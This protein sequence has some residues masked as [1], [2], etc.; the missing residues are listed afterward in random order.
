MHLIQPL[1]ILFAGKH[2]SQSNY[3]FLLL[4]FV[5]EMRKSLKISPIWPTIWSVKEFLHQ[6]AGSV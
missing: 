4:R 1:L 6:V 5:A 3:G 2:Q